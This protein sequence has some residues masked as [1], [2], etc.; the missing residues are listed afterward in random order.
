MMNFD[1]KIEQTQKIVMTFELQQAISLLQFSSLELMDFIQKEITDNPVME[2]QEKEENHSEGEEEIT[3]KE[4]DLEADLNE[5]TSFEWEDYFH[6]FQPSFVRVG[7][8]IYAG[9]DARSPDF[10]CRDNNLQEHLIFQLRISAANKGKTLIGEYLIG[11]LDSNGYL[12]G[13]ISEHA[14]YLGIEE[15]KVLEVLQLIQSFEPIGSGARTLKECLLIQLQACKCVPPFT[16]IIIREF[17]PK[18]A[19]GKCR[20][21]AHSIGAEMKELQQAVDF[22]RTLNPKPGSSL[23]GGEEVRYLTPDVIVERVQG[24]YVIMVNDNIPQLIINPFYRDIIKHGKEEN[25]SNFIKKRMESAL[26]LIRSIEQRCLTL[27]KVTEQIVKIQRPFLEKGIR[28]FKPL[29]LKDVAD[30]IGIHESTVSRATT[31][32]YVQTPRGLYPLKFFF[33]GGLGGTTGEVHSVLSIKS[34][35]KELVEKEGSDSPYS[36]QQITELLGKEGIKISRRAVTKYRKEMD[37]PSSFKRR[38]H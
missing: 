27:Y 6:D 37:I 34:Y 5:K 25:V 1:L 36:D 12:Q 21:I 14:H 20:E 13:E 26:W 3:K 7:S 19:G 22:I 18:L 10:P 38:R 8:E 33:C 16:E 32:K 28:S 9:G 30:E 29:T 31:N 17:L 35:L 15:S 2:I 11:N 4:V 24:E 23:G